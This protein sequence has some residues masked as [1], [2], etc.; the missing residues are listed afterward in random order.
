M[1]DSAKLKVW[2]MSM[3]AFLEGI[4][5]LMNMDGALFG[6]VVAAISGLCGYELGKKELDKKELDKK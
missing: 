1:K 5:M 3:L 6:L 2:G 4:A